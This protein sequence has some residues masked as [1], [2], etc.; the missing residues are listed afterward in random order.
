MSQNSKNNQESSKHLDRFMNYMFGPFNP[1]KI[2]FEQIDPWICNE[3][4]GDE[5]QVAKN[6]ILDAIKEKI[7][8]RWLYAVGELHIL[9]AIPI[10]EQHLSKELNLASQVEI[11]A[12]II[13]LNSE[14]PSFSRF[15]EILKTQGN[16]DAKIRT[17]NAFQLLKIK[18]Q[19]TKKNLEE[20]CYAIF[21]SLLDPSLK[22]RTTAYRTLVDYIY[23]MRIFTPKRDMILELLE[24]SDN[25]DDWKRAIS[26][27]GERLQSKKLEPF[28]MS[29]VEEVLHTIMD[30]PIQTPKNLCEIC[31]DIPEKID[32]DIAAGEKIPSFI[33]QLDNILNVG[34]SSNKIKRCPLCY[35]LYIYCYSYFYYIAG[36]SEEE[37]N[38]KIATTSDA[39]DLVKN[40][41][42]NHVKPKY[43]IYCGDFVHIR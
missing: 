14:H 25:Y 20:F 18:N 35:R 3:L 6:R 16:Q 41:V 34:S 37:E 8:L 11:I 29:R 5:I 40:Y 31:K 33:D 4:K 39:I 42:S 28:Q 22:V 30:R 19:I 26:M 32:A 38:L 9:Q 23:D 2:L 27:F 10:L 15:I 17:L 13:G 24:K 43:L 21:D 12:T 7:D 1:S 36:Q